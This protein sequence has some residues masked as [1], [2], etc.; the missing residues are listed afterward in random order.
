M[1]A[2]CWLRFGGVFVSVAGLTFTMRRDLPGSLPL[3]RDDGVID[4]ADTRRVVGLCLAAAAAGQGCARAG[5]A[6]AG[7][8]QA[9][10]F[11]PFRF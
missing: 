2:V 9:D 8:R 3:R 4:P 1:C 11:G 7:A 5:G 10:K 6:A